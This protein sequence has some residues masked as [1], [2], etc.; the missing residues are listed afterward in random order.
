MPVAKY[1]KSLY[2]DFP[3]EAELNEVFI[4]RDVLAHNHLL[5]INFSW[6]NEKG[7]NFHSANRYSSGD[8]KFKNYVD[9][10]N[11]T[12]KTLGLNVI[13]IKVCG[14]DVKKVLQTTWKILLFLEN[15]NRNQCYVSHLHTRHKGKYKHFGEIIGMPETCT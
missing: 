7:M 11:N 3:F 4:L 15:K 8:Y 13:P 14:S 2:A 9:I 5:E 1:L 10:S 12:T 6:D